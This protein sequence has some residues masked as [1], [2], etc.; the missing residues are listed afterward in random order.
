MFPCS[1]AT[2]THALTDI[3]LINAAWDGSM[4]SYHYVGLVD[5]VGVNAVLA[6][7]ISTSNDHCFRTTWLEDMLCVLSIVCTTPWLTTLALL[8]STKRIV[9]TCKAYCPILP[10]RQTSCY[11]SR[12]QIT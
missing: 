9:D 5:A 7:E 6:A 12:T 8:T 11:A 3:M 1:N 10:L 2:A 4:S